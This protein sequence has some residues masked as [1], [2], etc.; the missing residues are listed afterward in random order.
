MFY[1]EKIPNTTKSS[2]RISLSDFSKGLN[3]LATENLLPLNYAVNTFNFDFNHGGLKT[4]LGIRELTFYNGEYSKNMIVPSGK[5]VLK[6]WHFKR[7]DKTIN[8]FS[9]F[10]MIYCDDGVIYAGRLATQDTAFYDVGIS[11]DTKPN[12]LNY[13]I[14]GVDNFLCLAPN[15]MITYNGLDEPKVF[16][17]NIP[18]ITSVALHAERL[19]ATTGGDQSQLWFSDDLNP[20]NWNV[21]QFDGGYIELTDERGTLKKVVESNNYLYIIREFGISRVSGWG[22]QDDFTV[23]NLYLSTGKIYYNSAVLCGDVIMMMCRDGVY[24]FNGAS[25]QRLN[26]G[27][28]KY[29]KDVENN[30]ACG[31]FLDG[32][33]YLACRLNFDDSREIASETD[34]SS[35]NNALIEYDLTTGAINIMRGI[36]ICDMAPFQTEWFSKLVVCLRNEGALYEIT[37]LGRS[38]GIPT[39]KVWTSPYTDMGYALYKK[40]IKAIYLNTKSNITLIINADGK[41]YNF[42]VERADNPVR[43][44]INLA[45]YK[46]NITFYCDSDECEISNPQIEVELC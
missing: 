2:L 17:E 35:V 15:K 46:F 1:S 40:N 8:D 20:T 4:G 30:N 25:M 29:I 38:L 42:E 44:P 3:T 23:K 43:V 11:F 34:Y 16:T 12:A 19:F 14:D 36:D 24:C 9:P 10:L 26:L 22:L 39:T 7:F 6:F 41:E 13:R 21:D 27:I 37:H 5:K 45:A 33:Y 32:K 18:S 31:A 28:D